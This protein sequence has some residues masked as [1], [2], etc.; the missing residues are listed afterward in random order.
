MSSRTN[1]PERMEARSFKSSRKCCK[2][3]APPICANDKVRK[4]PRMS[5]AISAAT[6]SGFG[7]RLAVKHNR[8]LH[9]DPGIARFREI[10]DDRRQFPQAGFA[11]IFHFAGRVRGLAAPGTAL[12][13][14]SAKQEPKTYPRRDRAKGQCSHHAEPNGE[15]RGCRPGWR[16]AA[17]RRRSSSRHP[18]SSKRLQ[19]IVDLLKKGRLLDFHDPA[20]AAVGNA[21]LG[22]LVVGN[23]IFLGYILRTHDSR[24]IQQ[25]QLIVHPNFL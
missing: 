9:S 12:I 7:T 1:P 19:P 20:P 11:A 25:A 3:L 16:W 4:K 24:D 17:L 21:C 23:R 22:D 14:R 8:G 13:S 15:R 5:S 2:P 10:G 6:R 18:H